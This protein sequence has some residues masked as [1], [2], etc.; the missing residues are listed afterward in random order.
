[1][2]ATMGSRQVASQPVR[3]HRIGS[4][5]TMG[6]DW[7]D[8]T[9]TPPHQTPTRKPIHR[10]AQIIPGRRR[11]HSIKVTAALPAAVSLPTTGIHDYGFA[12]WRRVP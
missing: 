6:S 12:S 11:R 10:P 4:T 8:P 1:M 7:Y 3:H 9:T 5:S 2:E